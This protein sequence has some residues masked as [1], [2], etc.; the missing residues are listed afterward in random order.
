[1]KTEQKQDGISRRVVWLLWHSVT[2]L[3]RPR[4][5]RALSRERGLMLWVRVREL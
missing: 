2:R 4:A 1:M 5:S 3:L